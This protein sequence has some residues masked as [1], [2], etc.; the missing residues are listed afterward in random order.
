MDVNK[1]NTSISYMDVNKK[2]TSTS[3]INVNKQN[4]PISYKCKQT[5]YTDILQM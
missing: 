3:H 1:Q 2:N 4:T 5:K